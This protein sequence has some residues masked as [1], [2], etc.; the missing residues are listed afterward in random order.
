MAD[1]QPPEEERLCEQVSRAAG[2][3]EERLCEQVSRAAD[4]QASPANLFA[5]LLLLRWLSVGH[6]SLNK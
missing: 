6:A 2:V 1:G 3:A 5:Q 4:V